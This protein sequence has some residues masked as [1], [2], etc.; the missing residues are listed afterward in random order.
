MAVSTVSRKHTKKT[1]NLVSVTS[2]FI[3]HSHAGLTW[4][5]EDIWRHSRKGT[6]NVL[7]YEVREAI[8]P[9]YLCK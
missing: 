9:Y 8:L 5:G 1:S 7:F 2:I 6:K 3:S 4:Y